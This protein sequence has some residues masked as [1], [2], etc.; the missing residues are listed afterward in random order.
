MNSS[1]IYYD[2]YKPVLLFIILFKD[3]YLILYLLTIIHQ[4]LI[5]S[6]FPFVIL[7]ENIRMM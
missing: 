3:L 2:L 1:D 6:S 7:F 4:F 5:V